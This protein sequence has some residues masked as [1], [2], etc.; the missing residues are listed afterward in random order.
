MPTKSTP[1]PTL[2]RE[3]SSASVNN[4]DEPTAATA[5]AAADVA[6]TDDAVG[7]EP[8]V[9]SDPSE[10]R[11][12]GAAQDQGRV[13]AATSIAAAPSET[14]ASAVD[15]S[16]PDASK[17]DQSASHSHG[18][19]DVDVDTNVGITKYQDKSAVAIGIGTNQEES[20]TVNQGGPRDVSK[21]PSAAA[22]NVPR[23]W[24]K[25]DDEDD[26]PSN[27]TKEGPTSAEGSSAA[28]SPRSNPATTSADSSTQKP[29]QAADSIKNDDERTT[30]VNKNQPV[31]AHRPPPPLVQ[32]QPKAEIPTTESPSSQQSQP[33]LAPVETSAPSAPIVSAPPP[34]RSPDTTVEVG[35]DAP[36]SST[37]VSLGGGGASGMP[38][39]DPN[40]PD[41][42]QGA[43]PTSSSGDDHL[44][45]TWSETIFPMKLYDILCNPDFHHAISWMP[46]GRSWKVLNKDYFME[47]ICPQYFAQTRYESFIRQVN[48]WGFK[49]MRREGPDRSSY[50]HEHF[51]RGYPNMIDHMRRPAPGEKSRDLREEPDFYTVPA[52]PQLPP[53]DPNR[54]PKSYQIKKVGRPAG[55]TLRS[56]PQGGGQLHSSFDPVLPRNTEG[57]PVQV[58]GGVGQGMPQQQGGGGFYMPYPG[59]P[60]SPYGGMT[61]S[62]GGPQQGWPQAA[63]PGY[64]PMAGVYPGYPPMAPPGA[65]FYGQPGQHPPGMSTQQQQGGPPVSPWRSGPGGVGGWPPG[66]QGQ[67]SQGQALGGGP[68]GGPPGTP[69]HSQSTQSQAPPPMSAM[70]GGA[71]G[72]PPPGYPGYP[73]MYGD[74]SQFYAQQQAATQG[75]GG[76]HPPIPQGGPGHPSTPQGNRGPGTPASSGSKRGREDDEGVVGSASKRPA[77][78][79]Q[80]LPQGLPPGFYQYPGGPPMMAADPNHPGMPSGMSSMHQ[81]GMQ[82]GM[83]LGMHQQQQGAMAPHHGGQLPPHLQGGPPQGGGE[84]LQTGGVPGQHRGGEQGGAPPFSPSMMRQGPP[85][86][87]PPPSGGYP[88]PYTSL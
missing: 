10:S 28:A 45:R 82:S 48:G 23:E 32:A 77:P 72:G 24:A 2:P 37:G 80:G 22:E 59:M 75:H 12:D 35:P 4:D 6:A 58:M 44:S 31:M 71:G 84:Q 73:P 85:P 62:G 33:P 83:P 29:P 76:G 88:G 36:A 61:P 40:N 38:F 19:V 66:P 54:T 7:R 1:S 47:E 65:G 64:P 68:G 14:V 18:D 49:R 51:L 39:D 3:A 79:H 42:P 87:G 20:A 78:S 74:P 13:T 5:T 57:M 16:Q 46:H 9:K 86:G 26:A 63:Y 52:M 43:I 53:A 27:P 55:S 67:G 15:E 30:A 25:K 21:D 69:Q 8:A 60:M 50:Y 81:P 17:S 41:N 11:A 56:L 70:P 34:R